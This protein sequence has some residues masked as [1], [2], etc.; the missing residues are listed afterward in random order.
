MYD[1]CD[2]IGALQPRAQHKR[3]ILDAKISQWWHASI[4]YDGRSK[5]IKSYSKR[6]LD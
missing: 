4:L 3:Y 5:C 1:A 2:V 6:V